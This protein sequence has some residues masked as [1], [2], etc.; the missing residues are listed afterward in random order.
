MAAIRAQGGE[1]GGAGSS[2][3]DEVIEADVVD[4]EA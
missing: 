4:D 2:A 1:D 3:D